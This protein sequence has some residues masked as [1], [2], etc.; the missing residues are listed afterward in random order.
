MMKL[1][2]Q[3]S[4]KETSETHRWVYFPKKYYFIVHCAKLVKKQGKI[5]WTYMLQLS[6]VDSNYFLNGLFN[7]MGKLLQWLYQ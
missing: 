4:R 2:V 5:S 6:K 7:P 3:V 1:M